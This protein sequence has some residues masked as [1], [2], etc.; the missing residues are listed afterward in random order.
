MATF[1][2]KQ[3]G[4]TVDFDLD[5]DITAMRSHPDYEEVVEEVKQEEKP[6]KKTAVKSKAE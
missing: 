4:N 5:H 1:R 3:T 6:V 2:C